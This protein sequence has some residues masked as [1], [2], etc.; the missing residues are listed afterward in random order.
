MKMF[1]IFIAIISIIII[2]AVW[3]GSS[4]SESSTPTYSKDDPNRPNVKLSE[5]SFDFGEIN[6]KETRAHIFKI[7]NVGKS[8]LNLSRVSTSCD[9]TYAYIINANGEQSPK[10]SMHDTS[11]WQMAL[12]PQESASLKVYYKPSIMPVEGAVDRTINVVTN[13]PT[14]P[15]LEIKITATVVK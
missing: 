10:F 13:D 5:K 7:T 14:N 4:V 3:I 9:C 15:N 11:S 12:K 8:D 2:A 1:G 6:I